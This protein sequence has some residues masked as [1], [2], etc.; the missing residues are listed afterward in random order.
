[1][2][3]LRPS[4][5]RRKIRSALCAAG[6]GL[7]GDL[8]SVLD[9]FGSVSASDH[10]GNTQFTGDHFVALTYGKMLDDFQFTG[11]EIR[12]RSLFFRLFGLAL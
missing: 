12:Q 7:A 11:R 10:R 2:P 9:D 6:L 1:M 3:L 8:L 4:G 5:P